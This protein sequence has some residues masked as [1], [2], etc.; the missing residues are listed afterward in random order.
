[1]L[2]FALVGLASLKFPQILGNGKNIVQLTFSDEIGPGLLLW[3]VLLRP[4]ATWLCLR[5]GAPGGLFTPTM[6]LG[7]LLGDITGHLW[8][9]W[10]G[11]QPQFAE[12]ALIGSSAFLSAATM[13]PVS[14]TIFLVELTRAGDALMVPLLLATIGAVLTARVFSE[15]SIYSA[16]AD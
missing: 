3:L 1:V 15:R 8:E 14:S 2:V 9:R 6:T 12:Y 11:G 13:G 5:S 7:A 4:L 16:R 10:S